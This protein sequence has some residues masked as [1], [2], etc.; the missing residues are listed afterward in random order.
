MITCKNCN[1]QL[2]HKRRSG[3]CRQCFD[4]E[5]CETIE[6]YKKCKTCD[7]VLSHKKKIATGLCR[8]CYLKFRLTKS[9]D[10]HG[11]ILTPQLTPK[12]HR[13]I[14]QNIEAVIGKTWVDLARDKKLETVTKK[15]RFNDQFKYG[16]VA[17]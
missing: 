3:L 16:M 9:L 8:K 17:T 12:Q 4:K 13:T 5:Q 6:E 14:D 10:F 2:W 11:V 7:T 15:Y 1:K